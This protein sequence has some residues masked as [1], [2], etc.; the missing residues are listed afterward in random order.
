M[1]TSL[2][3]SFLSG[4]A[5]FGLISPTQATGDLSTLTPGQVSVI[6]TLKKK[7]AENATVKT[8][9]SAGSAVGIK[10]PIGAA[11]SFLSSKFQTKP[12]P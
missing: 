7:A 4:L 2:K 6:D 3:S 11:L 1:A 9:T 8:V 5:S 10:D 12:K